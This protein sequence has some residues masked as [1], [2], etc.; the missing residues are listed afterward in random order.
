MKKAALI[1]LRAESIT[2][3]IHDGDPEGVAKFAAYLDEVGD[4]AS[5]LDELTATTTVA[6]MVDAYIQPLSGQR[7][8]YAWAKDI[9]EDEQ[10]RVEEDDAE[11]RAA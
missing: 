1:Q 5:A 8:L 3:A 10:L 7:V 11:R 4:L 2:E 6:D 9:A